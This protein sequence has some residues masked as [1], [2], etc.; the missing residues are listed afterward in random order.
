MDECNLAKSTSN[1]GNQIRYD[2][3]LRILK[4]GKTFS[5][6]DKKD[7]AIKY[8]ES[9]RKIFCEHVLKDIPKDSIAYYATVQEQE[10]YDI[11]IEALNQ[12]TSDDC[13]SRQAV[14]EQAKDYGSGTF[15]IPVNSVKALSPVTPARKVG[16][17]I[18]VNQDKVRCSN[19]DIIHLIAQYPHGVI[20]YCPNCGSYN[21]SI[22]EDK[23]VD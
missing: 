12:P 9:N 20:D 3:Y 23:G 7:L 22:I 4:E 6:M 21:R 13:I 1:V 8:F 14:L 15:L 10:F 11:A 19:C 2:E 17:W 16:Y 5:K 18:R